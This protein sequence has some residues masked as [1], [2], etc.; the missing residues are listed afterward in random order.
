MALV[1]D[2]RGAALEAGTHQTVVVK[3]ADGRR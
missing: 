2:R 1:V 3:H